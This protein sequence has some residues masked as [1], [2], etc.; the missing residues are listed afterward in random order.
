ME[1]LKS[2]RWITPIS[3]VSALQ[4]HEA[5]IFLWVIHANKIPPHLGI[6]V[7]SKFYSLK[8]NGK[9]DGIA[10]HKILPILSRK[11]IATVFYEI[12]KTAVCLS[13]EAVFAK[14]QAT[15]PG[16]VTCLEPLK[17][18]FDCKNAAWLKELLSNLE[19]RGHIEKA[20]GW[21]LPED[22]KGI[23]NYNPKDIHRR[24]EQ[25]NNV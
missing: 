24:L 6:S 5:N 17:T 25:L 1:V 18:I 3:D 10:V 19:D 15:V 11:N 9:D 4:F 8:A 2:E 7:G 23:P 22:F 13:V 14:F 21:Q 16:K 20:L 12:Q